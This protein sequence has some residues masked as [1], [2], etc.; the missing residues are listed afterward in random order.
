MDLDRNLIQMLKSREIIAN[1]LLTSKEEDYLG[2]N[3]FCVNGFW[4][5]KEGV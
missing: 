3:T 1:K 5:K 4:M 2:K